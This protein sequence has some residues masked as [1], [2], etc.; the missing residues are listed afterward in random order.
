M[1]LTETLCT[2]DE[3]ITLSQKYLEKVRLS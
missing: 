2:V 1:E 3:Q